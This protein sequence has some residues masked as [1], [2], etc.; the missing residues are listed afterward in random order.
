MKRETKF[1]RTAIRLAVTA[2]LVWTSSYADL[3][4]TPAGSSDTDGL[5]D[6]TSSFFLGN[7]TVTVTLTDLE[8]NPRSAGQT[9]SGILFNASGVSGAA[10]L[11]SSSGYISAINGNGT[12]SAGVLTSPLSHWGADD[13]VSLSTI[14]IVGSMPYDLIIGPDSAGG[15]TGAGLYSN[16]NKGLPNF[17]PYVLGSATFTVNVPGI[18]PSSTLSGVTFEFG[19]TP[20]YVTAITAVPE[21]GTI[22]AGALLLLPFGASALRILR[23]KGT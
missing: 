23:N 6:A 4:I 15:F 11:A 10:T 3:Y 7:G 18:T 2:M 9:L 8:G 1:T 17:N 21:P 5:V 12:Y 14:N 20:D 19:T 16:A 22:L 13:G